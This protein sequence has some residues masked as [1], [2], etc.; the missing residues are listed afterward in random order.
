MGA[1]CRIH[2][3]QNTVWLLWFYH[4]RVYGWRYPVNPHGTWRTM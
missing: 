2:R 3:T 4:P 1:Q